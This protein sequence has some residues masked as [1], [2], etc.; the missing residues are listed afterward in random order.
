MTSNPD[1]T[2]TFSTEHFPIVA[3]T[4]SATL[5]DAN[6][7]NVGDVGETIS[8]GFT[9]FNTGNVTLTDIGVT[10]AKAGPVTCTATT[11]A[12]HT[13]TGCTADAPYSIVQADVDDG[14]VDNTATAHGTPPVG[15]RINSDPASAS[16][17]TTPQAPG[18]SLTKA[19]NMVGDPNGN[20]IADA[21]D[22]IQYT[23]VVTNSGTVTMTDIGV[24]DAKVGAVT[25]DDDTLAPSESTDCAADAVYTVTQADIDAGVVHNTATPTGTTPAGD[26]FT[27]LPVDHDVPTTNPVPSLILAKDA[28]LGDTNSNGAA[29]VAETIDY[30]FVVTNNGN[31]TISGIAVSDAVAG[32]VTCDATTLA[33]AAA[34]DCTSDTPYTVLQSDV[35]LGLVL[36]TATAAGND[37]AGNDVNSRPA[38]EIVP[39]SDAVPGIAL[40]KAGRV[41]DTTGNGHI[42]G[43]ADAGETITYAF[44][45]YN[46]GNVTLSGVTVTDDLLGPVTCEDAVLA[47]QAVTTCT[48]SD[49]TVTQE[50][51]DAGNVT[52]TATAAGLPPRATTPV[53]DEATKILPTATPSPSLVLAKQGILDDASSPFPG[54]GEV[55]EQIPYVFTVTNNGNVTVHGITIADPTVGAVAC[56]AITLA[57]AEQTTCRSVDAHTITQADVD[58]GTV[59]NTATAHG[60]GPP[61]NGTEGAAV[62]S[63]PAQAS[64][65][66]VGSRPGLGL[67]KAAHLTDMVVQ[68]G[69]ANIGDTV[70]WTFTVVNT[71]NVTLTHI[72]VTDPKAGAVTCE[73][74][75]LAPDASTACASAKEHE[76]TLADIQNG[77]IINLATATGQPPTGS[78]VTSPQAQAVVPTAP[79]V[80]RLF[81]VKTAT[82]HDRNGNARGDLGEAITYTFK[83]VNVGTATATD[84][85]LDDSMFGGPISCTPSTLKP[86]PSFAEIGNGQ[87]A[88]C[89]TH[90]HTVTQGDINALV[91]FVHNSA[92]TTG[93]DLAGG[94]VHSL[95]SVADVPV[96]RPTPSIGE[97]VLTKTA[98]TA[99]VTIGD[100]VEYTLA[101]TNTGDA[102][103]AGTVTDDLSDVLDD[104]TLLAAPVASTGTASVSGTTLTWTGSVAGESVA[105]ITYAVTVNSSGG[106]GVLANTAAI[107]SGLCVDGAASCS[108]TTTV[109]NESGSTPG[110]DL[111]NTGAP[112]ERWTL[113]GAGLLLAGA[114][115]VLGGRRRRRLR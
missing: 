6:G 100:V 23:F 49:H 44:L 38:R 24:T 56:D 108:T 51:V 57:P 114:S 97:L 18:L 65:P 29:D 58:N 72:A 50:D 115:F 105:T 99:T 112:I 103:L 85:H 77:P 109:E 82:L 71:G 111:P 107:D 83:V 75:A 80:P 54:L 40:V 73:Q 30:S 16:V 69:V 34:T 67:T 76:A 62:R 89:G 48:A 28:T 86:A 20:G 46:S 26:P 39:T 70:N 64:V 22:T 52:N 11:L 15:A 78:R 84:V 98:S 8:Y 37:P 93:K 35:D 1:S 60:F 106:N 66:T 74:T 87:T 25:C 79:A 21:G 59:D 90:T 19:H 36:N 110:N 55:G 43:L 81:L 45:V 68:N 9:V 4:K 17:P 27:G 47:P 10:D 32:P 92:V 2:N 94:A 102:L 53:T 33:P 14:S 91:Q 12:P 31:V 113:L 96:A 61:V 63:Q 41:N 101:V 95:P 42:D 3:I 7:N 88:T 13:S 5:N 104:A